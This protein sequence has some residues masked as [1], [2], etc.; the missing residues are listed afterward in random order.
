MAL[1]TTSEWALNSSY[2]LRKMKKL[3]NLSYWDKGCIE[4]QQGDYMT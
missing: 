1:F 3:E 2:C 4:S